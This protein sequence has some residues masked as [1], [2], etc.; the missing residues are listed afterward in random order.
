MV[1]ITSLLLLALHLCATTVDGAISIDRTM[2]LQ[3]SSATGIADTQD[4]GPTGNDGKVNI[5]SSPTG[6]EVSEEATGSATGGEA[7]KVAAPVPEEVSKPVAVEEPVEA[8]L[9]A[10]D[11]IV[12]G[13]G[14]DSGLVIKMK[15]ESLVSSGLTG[16]SVCQSLC[17][18]NY[19]TSQAVFTGTCTVNDE[20]FESGKPNFLSFF[21]FHG[22]NAQ[23]NI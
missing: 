5:V 4:E 21:T 2:F 7:S 1:R 14:T 8:E 11:V 16:Y 17:V 22:H 23:S 13:C 15:K 12:V 20:K 10:T 9:P 18:N 19:D 6:S 3:T